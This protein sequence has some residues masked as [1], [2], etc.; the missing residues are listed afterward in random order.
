MIRQGKKQ[1]MSDEKSVGEKFERLFDIMKKLRAPGGCPWDA[2][3]TPKSLTRYVLEEAHELLEAIESGDEKHVEE[4]LGDL[5]LQVVFQAAIGEEGS[6]IT[7]AG[8][9]D[10]ISEKLI[11]RHP[12]VF[13]EVEAET[14]EQVSRNWSRIKEKEKP[15]RENI[16]SGLPRGMPALLESMRICERVV[17][18]GFDWPDLAGVWEKLAEEVG[19][20]KEA[21]QTGENIAGEL[22]DLL[23]VVVNLGRKFG[24]DSESALLECNRRF[25]RRFIALEKML[26]PQRAESGKYPIDYLDSL[27]NKAKKQVG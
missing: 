8:V 22:G 19:E 11:R 2:E 16:F 6:E 23:F 7:M 4:E 27:W 1:S 25:K 9:I 21:E 3:Q 26:D 13:G 24:I 18:I 20:L 10:G 15:K 5:L 14:P 12:H 17:P